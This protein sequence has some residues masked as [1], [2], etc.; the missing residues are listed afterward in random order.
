M[1]MLLISE[2]ERDTF[3]VLL[4]GFKFGEIDRERDFSE[5]IFSFYKNAYN[6]ERERET[7]P[8][9]FFSFYKSAFNFKE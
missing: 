8:K 6:S 4:N 3:Q 5:T 9:T 2:S 7:F 1:K